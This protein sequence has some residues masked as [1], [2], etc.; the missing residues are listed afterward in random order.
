[1]GQCSA[2]HP[3]EVEAHGC[4]RR[5]SYMGPRVCLSAAAIVLAAMIVGAAEA[6]TSTVRWLHSPSGNIECEV[7]SHDVRGTYAYCQ[8]FKPLQTARL[9]ANGHTSICAR[10]P[11][12]VGNGAENAT[13]LPYGHSLRVGIFR[14]TSTV[15]GVRCV[16][17]ASGH[18]FRIAREGV[19]TF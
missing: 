16:V 9:S 19:T 17:I 1:M 4:P 13:N 8:T 14:C 12:S 7:A 2:M 3:D 15:S 10:G 5:V 18:G 11:C 6:S